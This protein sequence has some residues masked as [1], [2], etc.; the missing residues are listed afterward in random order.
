MKNIKRK[1]HNKKYGDCESLK[2]RRV[3]KNTN[4][5]LA[6]EMYMCRVYFTTAGCSEEMYMCRVYVTTTGRSE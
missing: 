3:E 2:M 1:M 4:K 5:N 6:S